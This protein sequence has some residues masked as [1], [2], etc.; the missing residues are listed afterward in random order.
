MGHLRDQMVSDMTLYGYAPATRKSYVQCIAQAAKYLRKSPAEFVDADWEAYMRHLV[1]ERKVSASTLTVNLSAMAC[2]YRYTLRR[3]PPRLKVVRPRR[4]KS[5][6]RVLTADEIKTILS[7]V[8]VPVLRD[9]LTLIYG[10][11]LR[12]GEGCRLPVQDVD[13]QRG[14]LRVSGGK[15]DRDRYVAIPQKLLPML[16]SHMRGVEPHRPVFRTTY[17]NSIDRRWLQK[18]FRW[19]LL[20]SRIRKPASIHTLRHSY[21]THLLE[22]GVSLRVIQQNLGHINIQTTSV[23]LHVARHLEEDAAAH[24]NALL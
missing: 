8:H 15:G 3:T 24:I 23:Y 21:A 17:G 16:R 5:K 1:V 11:G 6:P 4:R 10:C 9:A 2:F 22:A 12:L 18:S 13:L 7:H 20:S 14:V 19:A